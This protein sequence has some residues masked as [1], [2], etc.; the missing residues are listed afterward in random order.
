MILGDANSKS[1]LIFLKFQPQSSFLGKFG[2]KKLDLS[3]L[4]ENRLKWCLKDA[5]SYSEI[6]FLNFKT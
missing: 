6:N 1:G 2:P 3:V 5:D 4:L